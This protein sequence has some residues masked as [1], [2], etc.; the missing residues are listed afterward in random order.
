MSE[1]CRRAQGDESAGDALQALT[2]LRARLTELEREH[3]ADMLAEGATWTAV[4]ETA[5]H[6]PPGCAPPPPRRAARPPAARGASAAVQRVLV[7]GVARGTVR[8]AR[9]EAAALGAPAVGTEHL[10]LALTSTAPEPVARALRSA[11][12]DEHA[13]RATLQPTIVATATSPR[14]G[15]LHA[16]CAGG[17]GGIAARGRRTRRRLHRRRPSPARASAQSGGRGGADLDALGVEAG[18]VFATLAGRP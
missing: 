16:A 12:I 2:A 6:H 5:G 1:L 13:L 7:T 15:R 4:A 11:G 9:R 3:V 10:L 18:A 17:P 14:P 8:L